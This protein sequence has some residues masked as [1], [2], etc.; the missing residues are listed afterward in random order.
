MK[1]FSTQN[2]DHPSPLPKT[3]TYLYKSI[4]ELNQLFTAVIDVSILTF[5]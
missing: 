3:K 4:L 1:Y 5:M 2:F